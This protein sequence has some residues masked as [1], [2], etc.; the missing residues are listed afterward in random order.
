MWRQRKLEKN[1]REVN[2]IF[3][4]HCSSIPPAILKITTA[5]RM[6][7]TTEANEKATASLNSKTLFT[8]AY[9]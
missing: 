7:V 5:L 1:K 4:A 6:S 3:V 8:T 2:Q 9:P